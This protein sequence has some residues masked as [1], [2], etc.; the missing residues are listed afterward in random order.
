MLEGPGTVTESLR[1][2]LD[3]RER[4]LVAEL[5]P[6]KDQVAIIELELA[7]LRRARMALTASQQSE[8][9]RVTGLGQ[10]PR[11]PTGTVSL[12]ATLMGATQGLAGPM[13]LAHGTPEQKTIKEMILS[14]LDKDMNFRRNGATVAELRESIK[15][16]FGKDIE[17]TSLSPQLSRLRDDDAVEV[18]ENRWK[19]KRH[20]DW[21]LNQ[22][23]EQK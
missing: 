18:N 21:Y 6:A 7:E 23:H 20:R 1:E 14:V 9:T 16:E 19:R 12:A 11:G 13:T 8:D 5:L 4:E 17:G 15:K 22:D 10:A 3:R 2:F